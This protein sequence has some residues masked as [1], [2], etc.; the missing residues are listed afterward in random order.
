MSAAEP[1]RRVFVTGA[2]GMLGAC[3]IEGLVAEGS[4]VVALSRRP[5]DVGRDGLVRWVRGD[6]AEPGDWMGAVAGCG[7]VVHLAGESIAAGRWTPQRKQLLISSR[8]E[9]ARNLARAACQATPRP[10]QIVSASAVGYY[11]AGGDRELDEAA[12][13]GNDFLARL[14]AAWEGAF[15]AAEAAGIPAA[16]IRFGVVLSRRGGALAKMLTPFR[17]GLGG[18][19][20]PG[21]RFFPWVHEADALGLLHFVL[22]RTEPITGPINAVAPGVVRMRDFARGL[23]R[24]L[25]R[26]ALLPLPLPALRLV[27]GEAADAL[28]PGQRVVPGRA[29]ALGYRFVHPELDGALADL[30]S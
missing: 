24:Q 25:H 27:L 29:D 6:V 10:S 22:A 14:C 9:G 11:G 26:P 2:S 16:A 28:V 13:A 21:D 7:Q 23:G 18:P 30:L 1:T 4:E 20:G 17:L 15:G 19:L 3:L 8:V 12:P 5:R